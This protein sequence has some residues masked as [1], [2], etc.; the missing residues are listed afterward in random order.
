MQGD[1]RIDRLM[2]PVELAIRRHVKDRQAH[3][4]IYNRAYEAIL[5]SMDALDVSAQV[6][7]KQIAES[8]KSL[9]RALVLQAENE[10]LREALIG[11]MQFHPEDELGPTTEEYWTPEY[12]AAIEAARALVGGA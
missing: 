8:A 10:R 7:A 9:Q 11:L 3:I 4:D 6:T 5:S 1:P 12:K 2:Y